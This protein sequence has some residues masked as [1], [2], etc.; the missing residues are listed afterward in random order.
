MP[1]VGVEHTISVF[2]QA[3]KVHAL[4]HAAT[5]IGIHLYIQIIKTL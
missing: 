3:K 5:V 4:D 1:R 2:E